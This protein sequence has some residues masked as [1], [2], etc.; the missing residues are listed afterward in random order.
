M[1][2]L[3]GKGLAIYFFDD[4]IRP[5]VKAAVEEALWSYVGFVIC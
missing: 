3:E 5:L 2:W 1:T 4:N